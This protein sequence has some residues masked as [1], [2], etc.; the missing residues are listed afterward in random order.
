MI[1]GSCRSEGR[2]SVVE[3]MRALPTGV[4][5]HFGGHKH[6][7][8]FAVSNEEIHYFEQKMV[9][10]MDKIHSDNLILNGPT[11]IEETNNIDAELSIEEIST[12][13]FDSINLLA[14]FGMGNAKPVFIFKN[15][16]PSS[17]RK[18]GKASEHI[19]FAFNRVVGGRVSAI[20]F[21][22]VEENWAKDASTGA[23]NN[24]IFSPNVTI[25]LV[26]TLEKSMYRGRAELRLRVVDVIIK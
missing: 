16:K 26:A 13:L 25:D 15:V 23:L 5:T 20:S 3:L 10:A 19:E 11:V 9:V 7:G 18:F 22:G 4:L 6:S 12:Q 8:G 14:P 24:G 17:V 1:K 21:F 2:T